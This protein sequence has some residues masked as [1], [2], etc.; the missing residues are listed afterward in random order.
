MPDAAQLMAKIGAD[1]SDAEKEI[2]G[3]SSK[4]GGLSDDFA[5]GLLKHDLINQAVG[6]LVGY[7]QTAVQSY[8]ENERLGLSLET[9]IAREKTHAD[10]TLSMKTAL[11]QAAPAAQE[12]LKWNQQLAINS[13]FDEQGVAAAFRTVEAYGFV[14]D[15]ADKAAITA[16][17]LTQDLVDFTAG[18]GQTTDVLNRIAASL[19]QIQSTGQLSGREVRELA[20]AGLNI[21]QVLGAALGKTTEQIVKL[22]EQ[23][24][25]PANVA[26]QA[27]AHSIEQDFGGAALRQAGTISGLINS[28]EDLQKV[29]AREFLGPAIKAAQPYVQQ[30]V[31]T[32]QTPAAKE[33][34]NA[35]GAAIGTLAG[36][37][38]PALISTGAG[39]VKLVEAIGTEGQPVFQ[40]LHDYALP[41]ISGLATALAVEF[42]PALVLAIP[43][44]V[45]TGVA[46]A[47]AAAP[48]AALGLIIASVAAAY[49][50][51][52]G[53]IKGVTDQVLAQSPAYQASEQAVKD[54]NA[55][56]DTTKKLTAEQ[57]Q[58]LQS[59]RAEQQQAIK[60]FAEHETQYATFGIASGQTTASLERER[61]AIRARSEQLQ[62][63][64]A[65]LEKEIQLY[66]GPDGRREA[67]EAATQAQKADT[68][69]LQLSAEQQ[70]KYQDQLNKTAE[71]GADA[72][73]KLQDAQ[74]EFQQ[75]EADRASGH[76]Q[77][78]GDIQA[79]YQA[80]RIDSFKQFQE[81]QADA[82]GQY[83]QKLED[84]QRNAN[85]R[86]AQ[87][88]QQEQERQQQSAASLIGRLQDIQGRAADVQA[89]FQQAQQDRASTHQQKL[90]DIAAQGAQKAAQAEQNYLDQRTQAEQ[91]YSDR[92]A[93]M[94]RQLADIQ[95]QAAQGVADRQE[96]LGQRIADMQQQAQDRALDADRQYHDDAEQ[97]KQDH[98]DRLEDLQHRL[99]AATTDAQRQSIQAQID[100]E[101]ENYAKAESRAEQAYQ[102][103]YQ[104]AAEQLARQI[105]EA[106]QAAQ[107]ADEQAAEQLA[108]QEQHLQEQQ[109]ALDRNYAEQEAQQKAAYDNAKAQRE[110]ALA[111]Q[112]AAEQAAYNKSSAQA[113]QKR[114]QDL[115]K[116]AEQAQKEKAD[117]LAREQQAA[118]H[119]ARAQEQSRAQLSQQ[120]AD[121]ER[122]Y[123]RSQ[124]Q[125]RKSY[126]QQ[127]Q[128][129]ADAYAK[130]IATENASF[131][132]SEESARKSYAK[133]EQAQRE[134]LGK[135]LL[136]YETVQ[137]AMGA[138]DKAEFD[139]RAALIGKEFG[140][141][142]AADKQREFAALLAL[143]GIGG[144]SGGPSDLN[145]RHGVQISGPITIIVQGAADPV[146]NA[147]AVQAQLLQLANRNGTA[148]IH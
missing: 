120:I 109:D 35:L 12:L 45:A 64:S 105:A 43:E 67:I 102:R 140:V 34:I 111:D 148:G 85:T 104:R 20:L 75:A 54:Y 83:H 130:Q 61:A 9:L 29:G 134:S 69:Q 142:S 79:Q 123:A 90:A 84:I 2:E 98:G 137:Q 146:A 93:D 116:L 42:V 19:G 38:I 48:F 14:S 74:Q 95:E 114:D 5:A 11:E 71:S 41:L 86:A 70:K 8:A 133:Q 97:R 68:Q 60:T 81:K 135:Q 56:S 121:E 126:D 37:A 106:Q 33:N 103:Q 63:G 110:S 21:D 76:Q 89:Q 50:D 4:L 66:N 108:R 16:K 118:E 1:T 125:Q 91:T 99:A 32:L 72:Y 39:A 55:A 129:Q 30:L 87:A 139:R 46:A 58:A 53:K 28:L 6:A 52:E 49:Q 113:Q 143:A 132:Q 27:I 25:I 7:G 59:L 145:D 128:Q 147:Q 17:R 124:E 51:F 82:A 122:A 112:L 117:Y 18:S 78:L 92:V 144:S 24:A 80:Q 65:D 40:F 31:D 10:A 115:L 3:F 77:K 119:Y 23:G 96:Q 62:A 141:E 73:H 44:I 47:T 36:E 107:R 101:N 136:A 131:A 138:I 94:T 88:A 26:I 22:R 13:P 15:S 127:R 57:E 100:Q